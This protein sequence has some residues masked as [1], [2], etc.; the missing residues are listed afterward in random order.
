MCLYCLDI[1]DRTSNYITHNLINYIKVWSLFFDFI[2]QFNE[3]FINKISVVYCNSCVTDYKVYNDRS[4]R[5]DYNDIKLQNWFSL[6]CINICRAKVKHKKKNSQTDLCMR[7]IKWFGYRSNEWF[8]FI[9]YMYT[10]ETRLQIEF[11]GIF[12]LNVYRKR[13]GSFL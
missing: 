9:E 13:F 11:R 4:K 10:G 7:I 3:A 5:T 2:E 8:H 6:N 12:E 1:W